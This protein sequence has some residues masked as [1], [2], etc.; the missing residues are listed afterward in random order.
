MANVGNRKWL[1]NWTAYALLASIITLPKQLHYT[2]QFVL[3]Q[4]SCK[5]NMSHNHGSHSVTPQ[6]SRKFPGSKTIFPEMFLQPSYVWI[7]RKT[8]GVT[9][10]EHKTNT[11]HKQHVLTH[12]I[13]THIPKCY[14]MSISNRS[15]FQYFPGANHIIVTTFKDNNDFS[16]CST[17]LKFE[18][19]YSRTLKDFLGRVVTVRQSQKYSAKKSHIHKKP[20][21]Q[22]N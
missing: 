10:R 11:K 21:W 13:Q 19:K 1:S 18:G 5:L 9:T 16:G 22:N 20:T 3:K 4:L 2:T 17:A 7:S 8:A 15:L 6:N 14:V 12:Q